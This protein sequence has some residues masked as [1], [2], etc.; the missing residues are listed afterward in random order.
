MERILT[1]ELGQHVGQQVRLMGWLHRLRK[2]GEVNFLVL[3]D[4]S[5]IAQAVLSPDDIAPLHG[6]LVETV[7]AVTG[8]VVEEPQAPGGFEVHHA[9]V[10]VISP[11]KEDLLFAL[12]KNSVKATLPIFLDHA[13]VVHRAPSMRA[14]LK[15]ASG[16]MTCF[17][18]TLRYRAFTQPH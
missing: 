6:L 8:T 5:G 2:M 1:S 10:E 18:E 4:R 9:T 14:V 15:L 16:V 7:L 12:Y 11:V 3:R 17:R 13:V